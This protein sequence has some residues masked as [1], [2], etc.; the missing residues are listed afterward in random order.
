MILLPVNMM[1]AQKYTFTVSVSTSGCGGIDGGGID[2]KFAVEQ[3]KIWNEGGM[4]GFNTIEECRRSYNYI[5]SE[6][7]SRGSCRIKYIVS[8]CMP[9][10]GTNSNTSLQGQGVDGSFFSPNSIDEIKNWSED[11][12]YRR[13]A[14]D[15]DYIST[16]ATS[17][18]TGDSKF[19][20][21]RDNYTL[22]GLMPKGSTGYINNSESYSNYG[23]PSKRGN[24]FI[25]DDFLNGER[26]FVSL[27]GGSSEDLKMYKGELMLVPS[28]DRV[29]EKETIDWMELIRDDAKFA[30]S[31]YELFK[32]SG[33][34]ST[35]NKSI[36][37]VLFNA[38]INVWSETIDYA[39]KFYNDDPYQEKTH[40]TP[41]PIINNVIIN[42]LE[43]YAMDLP[44]EGCKKIF[45]IKNNSSADIKLGIAGI[46]INGII[47]AKKHYDK[48]K[49][50]WNNE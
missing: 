30:W 41:F 20:D 34:I 48:F 15:D 50:L 49:T 7:Y 2:A 33:V 14:L 43:D 35:A 10:G 19:D 4:E 28:V 17:I 12:T 45:G 13:L 40:I 31:I 46:T 22:S 38:N 27:G 39:I 1:F 47:L 8:P 3:A 36:P 16:E 9:S 32:K 42:T 6:S 24:V 21:A 26:P 37:G 25:P 44:Y 29:T 18:S 11:Y 23:F 5:I